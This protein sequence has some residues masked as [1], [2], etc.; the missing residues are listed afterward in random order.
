MS[1]TANSQFANGSAGIGH[2]LA[3]VPPAHRASGLYPRWSV[4]V[5]PG[6][7]EKP[8]TIEYAMDQI[9]K[10]Q[11]LLPSIQRNFTWSHEQICVLFDSI[12]RNYPI[13]GLMLWR[14]ESEQVATDFRFYQVLDKYVERFAEDNP[15]QD[16]K[17][18]GQ[19]FAVIDGQQRLTSLYIGL[20]GSYAYKIPRAW[21]PKA[22]DPKI[23]PPRKLYLDITKQLEPEENDNLQM[24]DFKFLTEHEVDGLAKD[25]P[26][27]WFEVGRILEFPRVETADGILDYV[28]DYL[29]GVGLAGNSYARKTLV[30]LYTAIRLEPALN[31]YVETSQ[32]IDH[33]LDIFIRT[34]KG[35]TPLSFSDLLMSITAANWE[36][37]RERVDEVVHQVRNELGFSINR[38]F[39]MKAAVVLIDIE[40][41]FKVKNFDEKSVAKIRAEWPDIHDA[42]IQSFRL[43]SSFGLN[44]ASLRAKN[45]VIPI[46]YYLFHKYRDPQSGRSKQ[47]ADINS[48]IRNREERGTIR[49]WLLMSLLRG[50]FGFAGDAL[51]ATLRNIIQDNIHAEHGFPLD[52]IVTRYLG[53]TRDITFD[54]EFVERL[55]RTQKDDAAC[56]SI[57]ALLEPALDFTQILHLDHL[58]PASAFATDRLDKLPYLA[59]PTIRAF[60]ADRENWNG[61]A[62]LHLVSEAENTSKQDKPLKEWLDAQNGKTLVDPLIPPGTDLSFEAFPAFI[63]ARRAYLRGKLQDLVGRSGASVTVSE[64][65]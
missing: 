5:M 56:F 33:V 29:D 36:E 7:Y 8:V 63:E 64:I 21:W 37:A 30:R 2:S 15:H 46:I 52:E 57:L 27:A 62:N 60:Y 45:A 42:I 28:I 55:L 58:H 31:Y 16:T 43:V 32:Q 6:S 26:G 13:N 51:L 53:T 35:G 19:F 9:V 22:N 41:R 48:P 50:V 17:G 20:K 40:V 25:D 1:V 10:R 4:T 3:Y 44:D 14:V 49:Q 59:D 34:N 18:H 39:V 11:Y 61:M 38:D 12:M 47:I 65:T 54:D 23:L 24:H